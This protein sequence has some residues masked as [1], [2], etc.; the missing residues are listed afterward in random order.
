MEFLNFV[1]SLSGAT[2]ARPNKAKNCSISIFHI[3]RST[4]A[5]G[6]S[7]ETVVENEVSHL[8]GGGEDRIVGKGNG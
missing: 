8:A 3:K 1:D 5:I 2:G 6:F 7:I 4:E